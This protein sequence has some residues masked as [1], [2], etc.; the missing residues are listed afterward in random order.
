[1]ILHLTKPRLGLSEQ[2]VEIYISEEE[3]GKERERKET[4]LSLN[5]I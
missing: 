2:Q 5:L 1:M 3:T 4:G